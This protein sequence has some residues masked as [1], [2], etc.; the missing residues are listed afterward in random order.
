MFACI[1]TFFNYLFGLYI[2]IYSSKNDAFVHQK[3]V[4][5]FPIW[6]G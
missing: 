1:G 4:N 5:S 2:N 6:K 3:Y